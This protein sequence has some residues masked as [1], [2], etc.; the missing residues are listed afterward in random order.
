[1][2]GVSVSIVKVENLW[3]GLNTLEDRQFRLTHGGYAERKSI[4]VARH[5]KPISILSNF[6][7]S[8]AGT[9][10][11][12]IHIWVSIKRFLGEWGAFLEWE[13]IPN[14]M[15]QMWIATRCRLKK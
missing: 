11:P 14:Q 1:M 9:N 3:F 4:L 2:T 12:L 7:L 8:P 13:Q 5:R 10:H 15:W 6:P